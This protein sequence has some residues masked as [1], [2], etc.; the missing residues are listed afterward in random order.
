MAFWGLSLLHCGL[1]LGAE[2]IA[3]LVLASCSMRHAQSVIALRASTVNVVTLLLLC[4][5]PLQVIVRLPVSCY[6]TNIPVQGGVYY[7]FPLFLHYLPLDTM[8]CMTKPSHNRSV[9]T[10]V[11][12]SSPEDSL[13]L[14]CCLHDGRKRTLTLPSFSR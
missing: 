4:P 12:V 14:I 11:I 13:L 8:S 7:D 2:D 1:S 5:Q 9:V 3:L 6:S 10:P